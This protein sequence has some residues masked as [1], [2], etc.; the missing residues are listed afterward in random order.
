MVVGWAILSPISKHAG[1]APGPVGDMSTGAR[2]WILWISL[3]IMCADSLVSL[4]PVVYGV[5]IK[6]A[7]RHKR[8]DLSLDSDEDLETPDRLVPGKWVI[9]GSLASIVFGTSLVWWVFGSEGIKPWATI[10][11]YLLGSLLSLLGC[12]TWRV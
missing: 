7:N 8:N 4:L 5:I 9:W 2:G 12:V 11:G 3:A 6:F 1:W 10:F